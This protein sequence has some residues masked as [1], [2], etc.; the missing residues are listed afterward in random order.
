M[1]ND[2]IEKLTSNRY[3]ILKLLYENQAKKP[4]G[5]TFVAITQIEIANEL[6]VSKMT[7]NSIFKELQSDGLVNKC[8]NTRGRYELSEKA[9]MIIE[10][11]NIIN[12]KLEED[13]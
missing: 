4:D 5:S 1:A 3:K 6:N 12:E 10:Q 13:R 8:G 9:L 2:L 7:V 11:M